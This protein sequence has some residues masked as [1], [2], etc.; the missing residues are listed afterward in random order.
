MIG[1]GVKERPRRTVL[2]AAVAIVVAEPTANGALYAALSVSFTILLPAAA[3]DV[4]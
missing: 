3:P 1:C 2:A 4:A